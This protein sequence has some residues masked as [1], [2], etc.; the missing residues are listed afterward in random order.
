MT[1]TPLWEQ[2]VGEGRARVVV[3]ERADKD[4]VLYL[5]W[6]Q[7]GNWKKRSLERRLFD[8][9]GRRLQGRALRDAQ[10]WAVEQA[11]TRARIL[12]G[13]AREPGAPLT[14]GEAEALITDP[15][16]GKYPMESA[17]RKETV[18]ELRRAV[19]VWGEGRLW[20]TIRKAD[21]RA[22]GR[23]R[24][25]ALLSEAA[26]RRAAGKPVARSAGYRGAEVTVQR[27]LTVAAWLRD[28][29]VIDEAACVAPADWKAELR[30]YW[31]QA[32]GT[33]EAPTPERP[34]HSLEEVRQLLAASWRVD[35]RFGLLFQL[36]AELR[37]GQVRR[38]WR[39]HLVLT[40]GPHGALTVP[41]SGKK[42]GTLVLLTKGQRRAVEGVLGARGYLGELEAA[43][44][45]GALADYPLF[46]AGKLPGGTAWRRGGR[47]TK[48]LAHPVATLARFRAARPIDRGTLDDWFREAERLAGIPHIPGRGAYGS[49]RTNVD[50]GKKRGISREGLK[51]WGGWSDTQV[52][53]AI[54]AEQEQEYAS[55]EAARL[56]AEIRGEEEAPDASE[57]QS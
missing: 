51:A 8:A 49:R 42:G 24:V 25:D 14:I 18:R 38:V 29:D 4:R 7:G 40:R 10:A 41:G 28:E 30:D 43:H 36:G 54:Y 33:T 22:L 37:L 1:E 12:A 2:A 47:V 23:A 46:P 17:H 9:K 35:P 57:G 32:Q 52:P 56:R 15:Q 13:T 53:D 11:T 39:R 50:E 6:R 5:R 26:Q 16:R 45:A 19:R 48:G 44:Q 27:V 3:Y 20:K 55:E 21:L 31:R 34:R